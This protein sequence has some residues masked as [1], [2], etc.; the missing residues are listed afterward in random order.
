MFEFLKKLFGKNEQAVTEVAPYKVEASVVD[1]IALAPKSKQPAD[2]VALAALE[3]AA[4]PAP[5][6]E[7]V[8]PVYVSEP[9]TASVVTLATPEPVAPP[10]PVEAPKPAAMTASK[11]KKAPKPKSEGTVI[12]M[13]KQKAKKEVKEAWP[14][15]EPKAEKPAKTTKAEKPAKAAKPRKPKAS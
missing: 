2:P 14:F 6:A 13:P 4:A 1:P 12:I 10:A 15:E 11:P 3:Q 9:E 5:V 7:E 8:K